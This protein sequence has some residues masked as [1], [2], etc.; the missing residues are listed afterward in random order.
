MNKDGFDKE[1]L[2]FSSV[3]SSGQ[4]FLVKNAG[5]AIALITLVITVLLTFTDVSF[6]GF[7]S[8]DF[9]GML[10]VMLLSSYIIYFSL[11][12]SGEALGRESEEY[13]S[14]LRSYK[15]VRGKIVAD[16]VTLLREFCS[17]YSVA[18]LDYRRKNYLLERGYS[19]EEYEA[20]RSGE[21]MPPRAARAFRHLE[22]MRAMK[23]SPAI[24]LSGERGEVGGEL[25]NPARKKLLTTVRILLP[26]TACMIFTISVM[27]TVKGELTPS[28]IIDGMLKLSALPIIGFRAYGA[29]YNYAR[30]EKSAWLEAK[31]RLLTSFVGTKE[32]N[33]S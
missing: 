1:I 32:K 23:I 6:G 7:V 29:G 2:E 33:G 10:T 22:K 24:L 9:G 18:E 11:E 14:A 25:E 8:E 4:L 13:L 27:L 17:E 19:T 3:M 15:S 28:V 20:Y 30:N 26:S 16:D 21:S 12:E 31:S 5:K